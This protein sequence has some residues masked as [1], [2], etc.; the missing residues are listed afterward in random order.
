VSYRSGSSGYSQ[1]SSSPARVD[2]ASSSLQGMSYPLLPPSLVRLAT[3]AGDA[4]TARAADEAA[5]A[6]LPV[7]AAASDVCQGVVKSDPVPVLSAACITGR[8]AGRWGG[9]CAVGLS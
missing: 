5:E 2:A 8:R 1:R 6:G 7:A 9:E 4:E 3:A